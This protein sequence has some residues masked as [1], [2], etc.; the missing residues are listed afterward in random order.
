MAYKRVV[1]GL[2]ALEKAA[3]AIVRLYAKY[4]KSIAQQGTAAE[5][6]A[7]AAFLAAAQAYCAARF[8]EQ[9]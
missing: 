5:Q 1:N 8:Q 4:G 2:G 9:P 3:C 7:G 6:S